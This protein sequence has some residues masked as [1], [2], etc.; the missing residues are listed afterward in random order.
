MVITLHY[1]G[2]L[3]PYYYSGYSKV[4][5]C[6]FQIRCYC[7]PDFNAFQPYD[8]LGLLLCK[9]YCNTETSFQPHIHNR[10]SFF[11]FT[12]TDLSSVEKRKEEVDIFTVKFNPA[13]YRQGV[14]IAAVIVGYFIGLFRNFLSG[15]Y[16]HCQLLFC[17]ILLC[18][19]SFLF[20]TG[21]IYFT[22]KRKN[23]AVNNLAIIL[24]CINILLYIVV[25]HQLVTDEMKEN[26][27]S[28]LSGKSAFFIHYILL[29]CLAYFGYTII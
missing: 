21:V 6:S 10:I 5:N 14:S 1:S 3:K 2:L 12:Y 20:S 24:S 9:K 28:D 18:F 16:G 26:Y 22:L 29:A 25:F 19:I 13:L 4:E 27:Y 8:G 17:P 11:S 7:C 23:I 15:E